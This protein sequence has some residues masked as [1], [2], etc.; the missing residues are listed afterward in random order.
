MAEMEAVLTESFRL[1][2]SFWLRECFR[3]L[4]TSSEEHCLKDPGG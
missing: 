2:E 3:R 1:T 4:E